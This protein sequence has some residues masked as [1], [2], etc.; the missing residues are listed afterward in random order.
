MLLALPDLWAPLAVSRHLGVTRDGEPVPV[1]M[2]TWFCWLY[3][4]RAAIA[5]SKFSTDNPFL[6]GM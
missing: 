3:A 4:N 5:Q 2:F 1:P 6:E